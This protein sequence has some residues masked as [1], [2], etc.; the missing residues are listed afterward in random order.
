MEF[1]VYFDSNIDMYRQMLQSVAY[2]SQMIMNNTVGYV[3]IIF[4]TLVFGINLISVGFDFQRIKPTPYIVVGFIY[5]LFGGYCDLNIIKYPINRDIKKVDQ[6]DTVFIEQVKGFPLIT[7]WLMSFATEVVVDVQKAIDFSFKKSDN[8]N[9]KKYNFLKDYTAMQEMLVTFIEDD[10]LS[11]FAYSFVKMTYEDLKMNYKG[12]EKTLADTMANVNIESM[13]DAM[14]LSDAGSWSNIDFNKASPNALVH[15]LRF[16]AGKM[17]EGDQEVLI[18]NVYY[19]F[20]PAEKKAILSKETAPLIGEEETDYVS[21]KSLYGY[22]KIRLNQYMHPKVATVA[23]DLNLNSEELGYLYNDNIA[24]AYGNLKINEFMTAAALNMK[25]ADIT[26]GKDSFIATE[27]MIDK[28]NSQKAMAS[29]MNLVVFETKNFIMVFFAFVA[30]L[31]TVLIFMGEKKQQVGMTIYGYFAVVPLWGLL[32]AFAENIYYGTLRNAEW[33]MTPLNV[34][35]VSKTASSGI[36]TPANLLLMVISILVPG[37]SFLIT[38]VLNWGGDMLI[39]QVAGQ[40]TGGFSQTAGSVIKGNLAFDQ[41]GIGTKN[42]LT[43]NIGGASEFGAD[44][45]WQKYGAITGQGYANITPGEKRGLIDSK[46]IQGKAGLYNSIASGNVQYGGLKPLIDA[47]AG[48]AS[49][50]APKTVNVSQGM[51]KSSDLQSGT[52]FDSSASWNKGV[53][54]SGSHSSQNNMNL[55]PNVEAQVGFLKINAGDQISDGYG[56]SRS[57]SEGYSV[58]GN[59]VMSDGYNNVYGSSMGTQQSSQLSYGQMNDII[60]KDLNASLVAYAEKGGDIK[61]M[62][63]DGFSDKELQ[64]LKSCGL[65]DISFN[66]LMSNDEYNKFQ[67]KIV[68]DF[69]DTLQFAD[70]TLVDNLDQG[71]M[72]VFDDFNKDLA[73]HEGKTINK[74]GQDTVGYYEYNDKNTIVNEKGSLND[75][76]EGFIDQYTRFKGIADNFKTSEKDDNGLPVINNDVTLEKKIDDSAKVKE[77]AFHPAHGFQV[78]QKMVDEKFGPKQ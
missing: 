27:N 17:K 50:L 70:K 3:L 38:R 57:V 44:M 58:S 20:T 28:I 25:Y 66:T 13:M 43:S 40:F 11:K 8:E 61:G 29:I 26:S 36:M 6:L 23:A 56:S 42:L 55:S 22:L 35:G 71:A 34:I 21:K 33:F 49:Y 52:R 45:T 41:V 32:A 7:G 51:H 76:S 12:E 73:S 37:L 62:A 31:A 2:F 4:T 14:Y 15:I 67:S 18:T 39:Q 53:Q 64:Q 59:K 74:W 60:S 16:E 46:N 1:T 47:Q 68:S 78:S 54:A 63:L 77:E 24:Y 9:F 19:Y 10:Y 69:A 30:P 48:G 5:S 72:K 75:I 65:S